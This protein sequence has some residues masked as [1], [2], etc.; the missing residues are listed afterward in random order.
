MVVITRWLHSETSIYHNS[1]ALSLHKEELLIFTGRC[2][3]HKTNDAVSFTT[4][5]RNPLSSLSGVGGAR[6][7][8]AGFQS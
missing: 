8:G 4:L 1:R 6:V 5:T 3:T 7:G 2:T